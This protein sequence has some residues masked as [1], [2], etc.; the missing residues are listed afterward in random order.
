MEASHTLAELE[1]LLGEQVKKLRLS[2]NIDQ[3]LLAE[4]AGISRRALQN[5]EAGAGSS[6]A[7]LL[8]VVRALGREDWLTLLAP[9]ATINPLNMVRARRERLRATSVRAKSSPTK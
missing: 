9:T 2:R 3:T 8:S 1:A 4:R 5:L 7:S 6:T